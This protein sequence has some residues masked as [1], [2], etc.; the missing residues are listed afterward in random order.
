MSVQK[1]GISYSSQRVVANK[2]KKIVLASNNGSSKGTGV[3][4]TTSTPSR[5]AS[6]N[7]ATATRSTAYTR[8]KTSSD[9]GTVAGSNFKL[10]ARSNIMALYSNTFDYS[11]LRSN[12]NRNTGFAANRTVYANTAMPAMPCQNNSNKFA[13]AMIAMQLLQQGLGALGSLNSSADVKGGGNVKQGGN[14]GAAGDTKADTSYTGLSD[15]KSAK[16]SVSLRS[17][18]ETAEADK[19]KMQSELT[20]IE[21]GLDAKK[22][23]AEKAKADMECIKKE[24]EEQKDVVKEKEGTVKAAEKNKKDAETKKTD[25]QKQLKAAEDRVASTNTAFNQACTALTTAESNLTK[26]E[27]NKDPKTGLPAEPGYTQAK[28]AVETAK[29]NKQKALDALNQAKGEK[30][31]ALKNYNNKIV[32]LEKAETDFETKKSELKTA[33]KDLAKEQETLKQLEAKKASAE[34]AIESYKDDLKKQE[35]LTKDIKKYDDEIKE[36]GKRL[37]EL[38]KK[39]DADLKKVDGKMDKLQEEMGVRADKIDTNNGK[40]TLREKIAAKKNDKALAKFDELQ[41]ERNEIQQRIDVRNLMGNVPEKI[42]D[43][44]QAM[45]KG[46]G[47][48]GKAIYMIGSKVVDEAAYKEK[49]SASKDVINKND[50]L[51]AAP[52]NL[53]GL[54]KSSDLS[55]TKLSPMTNPLASNKADKNVEDTIKKLKNHQLPNGF[56]LNGQKVAY[57]NNQITLNGKPIS[58]EELKAMM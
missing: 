49:L 20:Q 32:E 50:N 16:D 34:N 29:E 38:E 11:A 43:D 40:T 39:D 22:A 14:T 42:T 55:K 51:Q 46:T 10:A 1:P 21:S 41:Q 18:I 57:Q 19:T 30:D 23:D 31:N 6:A 47:A 24:V 48:D 13:N 8:I 7:L 2:G 27:A 3:G 4:A 25:A 45:R 56:Q 12:L 28:Q 37:T 9:V 5:T 44:G 15:M 33:E 17:A 52:L 53:S 26:A 35:E 36:Q 58:E 54:T